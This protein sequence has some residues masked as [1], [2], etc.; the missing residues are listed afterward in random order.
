MEGT[1]EEIL[2]HAKEFQKTKHKLNEILIKPVTTDA[3][4][5]RIVSAIAAQRG[6]PQVATGSYIGPERRHGDQPIAGEERRAGT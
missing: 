1:A 4:L 6:K 2:I 3:L 5:R